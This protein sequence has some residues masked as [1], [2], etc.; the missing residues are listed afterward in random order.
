MV[1]SHY[2]L[3]QRKKNEATALVLKTS[4]PISHAICKLEAG[5]GGAVSGIT[6]I[7]QTTEVREGPL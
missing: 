3:E 1:I 7:T 2:G 6:S 5:H 4:L